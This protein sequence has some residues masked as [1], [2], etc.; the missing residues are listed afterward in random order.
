VFAAT[1]ARFGHPEQTLGL[2]TLIGGVQRVAERAG[3]NFAA[4]LAY[5]FEPYTAEVM[6][7]RGL[8]NRVVAEEALDEQALAMAKRLASGPTRAIAANKALLRLWSQGGVE[9]ADAALVD[10]S[11]PVVESE[12][13]KRGL[14]SAL[15]AMAKG[16]K[17]PDLEF[18][19]R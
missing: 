9:A 4:E 10:L 6:H 19:G 14:K 15:D 1:S 2:T 17:R 11:M 7:Q 5:A 13:A 18:E 12:D 16:I 8:V 3:R